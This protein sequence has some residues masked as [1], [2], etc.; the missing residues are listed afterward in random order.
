[1]F[2][3]ARILRTLPSVGS[4]EAH[5]RVNRLLGGRN[6]QFASIATY[7]QLVSEGKSDLVIA[8]ARLGRAQGFISR[9]AF[10]AALDDV[11]AVIKNPASQAPELTTLAAALRLKINNAL[12]DVAEETML[13]SDGGNANEVSDLRGAVSN[14]LEF[15]ANKRQGCQLTALAKAEFLIAQGK[16]EEAAKILEGV[17][18]RFSTPA[19]AAGSASQV[20]ADASNAADIVA[21]QLAHEATPSSD[22]LALLKT[23]F[24]VTKNE[25]ATALASVFA[26]ANADHVYIDFFSPTD[27]YALWRSDAAQAVRKS[28]GHYGGV[29]SEIDSA[30][31][32][33][34]VPRPTA[35]I[36]VEAALKGTKPI[37]ST[38]TSTLPKSK[39]ESFSAILNK[40]TESC[41]QYSDS[42]PKTP[43]QWASFFAELREQIVDRS[44]TNR[45]VCL[46]QIKKESEA[47]PLVSEVIKSDKYLHMWK[48]FLARGRANQSSGKVEAAEAD[49]RSLF[50]LKLAP[51]NHDVPLKDEYRTKS[52]F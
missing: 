32:G 50:E 21:Y 47:I 52:V 6:E 8:A 12:L 28:L 17:V 48:A 39:D 43:E 38:L 18:E 42:A 2:R 35:T 44:K 29:S 4:F 19:P 11:N 36:D 3:N 25:D 45:A 1:M 30:V 49:L 46:T 20:T 41:K 10:K 14:D 22:A 9:G 16:Y 7:S 34:K 33:Y 31:N 27:R 15:L 24:G 23:K 37:L 40:L 5:K 26:A 13:G 51:Y